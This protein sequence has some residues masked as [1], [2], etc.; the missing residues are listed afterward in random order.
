MSQELSDSL[1]LSDRLD[2]SDKGL[3]LSDMSLELSDQSIA[4]SDISTHRPQ[5]TRRTMQTCRVE[6][7]TGDVR[8]PGKGNSDSH[9]ARPVHP[10]ITMMKG[11]RTS[12]LSMQKSLLR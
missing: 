8:L 6:P 11:I 1:V 3:E 7:R 4:L 5:C 2:S 10:I 9:G 12:R